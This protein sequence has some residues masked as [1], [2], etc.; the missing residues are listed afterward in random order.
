MTKE[1]VWIRP[2]NETVINTWFV[3][4]WVKYRQT[5]EK[6]Y[7]KIH[8]EINDIVLDKQKG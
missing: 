6:K 5:I 7:P 1:C 3:D 4:Y 8:K 2:E